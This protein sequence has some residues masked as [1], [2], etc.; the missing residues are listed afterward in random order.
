MTT[1]Q[2]TTTDVSQTG[3]EITGVGFGAWAIGGTGYG[4]GCSERIAGRAQ[5]VVRRPR[6]RRHR[7][8]G[9]LER[10]TAMRGPVR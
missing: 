8:A 1:T 3:L 10:L 6:L 2:I 5:S 9:R 4:F 7:P